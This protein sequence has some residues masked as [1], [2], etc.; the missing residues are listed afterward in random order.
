MAKYAKKPSDEALEMYAIDNPQRG[1]LSEKNDAWGDSMELNEKCTYE[2][3][4]N[5]A[6]FLGLLTIIFTP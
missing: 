3:G 1:I 6:V 5:I 4:D 2:M